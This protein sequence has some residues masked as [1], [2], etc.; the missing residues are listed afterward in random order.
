MTVAKKHCGLAKTIG[1]DATLGAAAA[2]ADALRDAYVW[3]DK[4]A[5]N[6]HT[7]SFAVAHG[8]ATDLAVLIRAAGIAS[9]VL[10]SL[11]SESQLI[12]GLVLKRT[13]ALPLSQLAAFKAGATFVPCDPAWPSERTVSILDE[14]NAAVV[15]ADVGDADGIVDQVMAGSCRVAVLVDERCAVVKV[16]T[17]QLLEPKVFSLR[18]EAKAR[19]GFWNSPEIMY[20]M[21]TSGSTG[22]PKGCVVPTAGVWHRFKW[23]TNLLGARLVSNLL[24]RGRS[25]HTGQLTLPCV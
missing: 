15:I 12:C 9:G 5:D 25:L 19:T 24:T 1:F 2:E 22:R 20:I 14:A 17:S 21:Y 3:Y 16:V 18:D 8:N 7:L 10:D 6:K 13:A 11:E 4:Q 23:G